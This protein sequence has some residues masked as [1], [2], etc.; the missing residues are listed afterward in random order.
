MLIFVVF[1]R[2]FWYGLV[3][4]GLVSSEL[5]W[6]GLAW[7]WGDLCC[8]LVFV[9]Y[10]VVLGLSGLVW[11]GLVWSGLAW[12]WRDCCAFV[13]VFLDYVVFLMW[14]WGGLVWAGLVW[15][16]LISSG[17]GRVLG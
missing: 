9:D 12:S 5:V 4:A 1:L 11:S 8:V 17:S 13:V 16:G 6:L 14:F 7:S 10:G 2:W 3:W 15:A